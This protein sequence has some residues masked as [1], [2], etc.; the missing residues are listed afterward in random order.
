[1]RERFAPVTLLSNGGDTAWEING[2][3]DDTSAVFDMFSWQSIQ[4]QMRDIGD[5]DS[6]AYSM[7]LY[8]STQ[9]KTSPDS[10]FT[11]AKTIESSE[12]TEDWRPIVQF[13][14]PVARKG[15]IVVTGIKGNSILQT[16]LFYAQIL[17]WSDADNMDGRMQ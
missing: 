1:M 4:Y 9:I 15:Y 13:N 17:G 6:V 2:T 3:A 16:N 11:L 8:T 10:T 5:D 14:V 7:A 12:T